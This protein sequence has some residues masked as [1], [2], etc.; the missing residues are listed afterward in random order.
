MH[1]CCRLVT[2]APRDHMIVAG[3]CNGL[4]VLGTIGPRPPLALGEGR[5]I[6]VI[7]AP[8]EGALCYLLIALLPIRV[9]GARALPGAVVAGAAGPFHHREPNTREDGAAQG[10]PPS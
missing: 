10:Y 6:A 8:T 7:E 9:A 5:I 2:L 3:P 4:V 1:T